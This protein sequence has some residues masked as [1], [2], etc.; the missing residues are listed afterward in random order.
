MPGTALTV[1]CVL[2]ALGL[3]PVVALLTEGGPAVWGTLA[4]VAVVGAVGT[5]AVSHHL[6]RARARIGSPL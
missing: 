3:G 5:T 2:V 4:A 1:T 6:P